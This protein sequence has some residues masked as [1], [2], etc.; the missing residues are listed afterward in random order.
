MVG[1]VSIIV[2]NLGANEL[3]RNCYYE[4]IRQYQMDQEK[5]QAF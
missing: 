1:W 5:N 2:L 4:H 3:G